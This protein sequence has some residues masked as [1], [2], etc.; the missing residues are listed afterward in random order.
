M[1]LGREGTHPGR[2]GLTFLLGCHDR[3]G[4]LQHRAARVAGQVQAGG[5]LRRCRG[6]EQSAVDEHG[7]LPGGQARHRE[8]LAVEVVH[9]GYPLQCRRRRRQNGV[10][11]GGGSAGE[12]DRGALALQV[13]DAAVPLRR[14]LPGRRVDAHLG[15][16]AR[17]A[18]AFE[19]VVGH[20]QLPG[21]ARMHPVGTDQSRGRVGLLPSCVQL[22]HRPVQI[23]DPGA[24]PGGEAARPL[25]APP[26]GLVDANAV[27]GLQGTG[28][29][30][31]RRGDEDDPAR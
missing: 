26:Q 18:L 19:D 16:R 25:A 15:H 17:D 14:G 23:D 5:Q 9:E 13:G 30:I 7:V 31:D 20:H 22:G 21:V 28:L 3:K 8:H 6:D 29:I 11:Q 27:L 4:L 1:P 12:A 2:H 10:G 24:K